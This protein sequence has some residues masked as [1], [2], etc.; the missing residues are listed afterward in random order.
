MH[1]LYISA[2][3]AAGL[4]ACTGLAVAAEAPAAMP[5]DTPMSMRSVE[6]VCTGIGSDARQDPR[7]NAYPLK[8]ELAGKAGQLI[9]NAQVTIVKGDEALAEVTCGGP[10]VLFKV[11]PGAYQVKVD[12]GEQSKTGRV[13]VGATGQ[14]R[15]I[16]RFPEIGGATSQEYV[17]K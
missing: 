7:W 5:F 13:N 8:V 17:P 1:R 3:T 6:A 9:G 15:I 11:M 2:G 12:I 4:F 10:W 14:A 16:I